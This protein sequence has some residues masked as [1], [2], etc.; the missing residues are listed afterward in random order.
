MGEMVVLA[1]QDHKVY[2]HDSIDV[3][4]SSD[5]ILLDVLLTFLCSGN[6]GLQGSRGD[7]GP[8]GPPGPKS[9][10]VQYIRWGKTSCPSGA[11]LVYKGNLEKKV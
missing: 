8:S 7:Q 1:T 10:G 6:P 2:Y 3:N 9:G 4:E 11:N 5:D